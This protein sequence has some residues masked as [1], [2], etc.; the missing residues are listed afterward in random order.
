MPPSNAYLT[1]CRW[2][3]STTMASHPPPSLHDLVL[4]ERQA[5]CAAS[6]WQAAHIKSECISVTWA[7]P[8]QTIHCTGSTQAGRPC[9]TPASRWRRRRHAFWS[10]SCLNSRPLKIGARTVCKRPPPRGI[11]AASAVQWSCPE[12][13]RII[14]V[15]ICMLGVIQ[16]TTGIMRQNCRFGQNKTLMKTRHLHNLYSIVKRL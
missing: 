15:F 3:M 2:I 8:S 7:T 6:H 10:T 4:M 1:K 13:V 11:A 16:A 9:C 14:C 12:T 5:L